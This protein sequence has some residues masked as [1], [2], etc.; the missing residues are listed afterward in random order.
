MPDLESILYF[1]VEVGNILFLQNKI[2]L[3]LKLKKLP[4]TLW[5]DSQW[6]SL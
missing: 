1:Y 4:N 3:C 6:I 5:Q 2:I